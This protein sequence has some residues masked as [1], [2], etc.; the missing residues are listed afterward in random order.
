MADDTIDPRIEFVAR[1]LA[2]RRFE[3]TQAAASQ[4]SSDYMQR[5][6][7]RMEEKLW[8]S[9]TEDAK[10]AIAALD[11][12]KSVPAFQASSEAEQLE[13]FE[14]P[15]VEP[16]P[17]RI[18]QPASVDGAIKEVQQIAQRNVT[19][20]VRQF[21]K[22]SSDR[23][24]FIEV[25]FLTEAGKLTLSVTPARFGLFLSALL[26]VETHLMSIAKEDAVSGQQQKIRFT[27]ATNSFV[28]HGVVDASMKIIIGFETPR[29]T[30]WFAIE[31]PEGAKLKDR[32]NTAVMNLQN[33]TFAASGTELS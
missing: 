17:P 22:A 6:L 20:E 14:V 1:A 10:A 3:G 24:E 33:D 32:L 18:D 4:P 21:V 11:K 31:I 25:T 12:N 16:A 30:R 23:G 5:F 9:L 2:R 8:P 26:E 27:R 15:D 7:D 13:N 28:R 29:G 19:H